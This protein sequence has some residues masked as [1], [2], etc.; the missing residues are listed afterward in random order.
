MTPLPA[1]SEQPEA[2]LFSDGLGDR[3]V[4]VDAATGDL[5]QILRI[6]P[7]LLAVPS[8]QFALR[9]RAAP[10][11]NF[12]HA[13]YARVG[14]IERDP[15]VSPSSPTRRKGPPLGKPRVRS[16]RRCNFN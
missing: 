16:E 7:Q 5:L 14:R 2:P 15:S 11:A 1:T 8:F 3:V 6:R 9:E 4:A 10:L 13:Y 12:R